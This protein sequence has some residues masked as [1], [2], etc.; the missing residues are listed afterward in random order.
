VWRSRCSLS[1]ADRQLISRDVGGVRRALDALGAGEAPRAE[2]IGTV[3]RCA[4]KL[5]DDLADWLMGGRQHSGSGAEPPTAAHGPS[6]SPEE[7][8]LGS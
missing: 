8:P 3:I 4:Q 7:A 5:A 2:A 1:R 6:R